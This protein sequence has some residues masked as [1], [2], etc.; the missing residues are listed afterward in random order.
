VLLPVPAELTI[1]VGG[2][3][4]HKRSS[5]CGCSRVREVPTL[6]FLCVVDTRVGMMAEVRIGRYPAEPRQYILQL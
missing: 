3:G 4:V 6:S 5:L 1:F 2:I